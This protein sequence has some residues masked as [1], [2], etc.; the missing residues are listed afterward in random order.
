MKYEVFI[1]GGFVNIPKR[2]KGDIVLEDLEKKELI[3]TLRKIPKYSNEIHDGFT[4]H[5]K[6][7]E[8]DTE[9]KSVYDEHNLPKVIKNFIDTIQS[10]K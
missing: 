2:F 7:V 1:N 8:G 9:V 3:D 4:Y 10:N 6:L 5:V